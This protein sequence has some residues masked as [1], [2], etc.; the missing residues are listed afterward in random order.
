MT[1]PIMHVVKY[2]HCELLCACMSLKQK[3]FNKQLAKLLGLT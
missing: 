3:D 1:K 2:V